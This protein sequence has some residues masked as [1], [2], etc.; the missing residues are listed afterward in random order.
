MLQ[1]ADQRTRLRIGGYSD[2]VSR[3]FDNRNTQAIAIILMDRYI[4]ESDG[5]WITYGKAVS[6]ILRVMA[7][8]ARISSNPRNYVGQRIRDAA[9]QKRFRKIGTGKGAQLERVPFTRWAIEQ[10]PVLREHTHGFLEVEKTEIRTDAVAVQLS[11]NIP[12]DYDDLASCYVKALGELTES[13]RKLRDCR[14][15]LA[16]F[17]K[18]KHSRS[19]KAKR[20]GREGGSGKVK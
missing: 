19:I 4:L 9:K 20:A 18:K 8:P 5:N 17:K 2:T 12:T 1:H 14:T 10:W 6:D 15:Q 16:D 13:R 11:P 7:L 3:E